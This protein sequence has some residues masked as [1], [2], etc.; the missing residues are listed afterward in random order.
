MW[1]MPE[2]RWGLKTNRHQQLGSRCLC[3][4]HSWS[5]VRQRGHHG[6]DR[7][8]PGACRSIPQNLLHMWTTR[9]R[10]PG[11]NR[12]L[13]A[14]QSRWLQ[15]NFS[16]YLCPRC[17][18]T[19]WGGW[20]LLGQ[21]QILR[22]LRVPLSKNCK[23]AFIC[24]IFS[25]NL[26]LFDQLSPPRQAWA[27]SVNKDNLKRRYGTEQYEGSVFMRQDGFWKSQSIIY[28]MR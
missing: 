9:P 24:N 28:W 11:R 15:T 6:A 5:Q 22:L 12:G 7:V 26:Q 20:Q 3:P 23:L 2:Q 27:R 14:V 19:L 25:F 17:R 1:I 10:E 16:C 8:G 13:H 4:L 21:R 18:F